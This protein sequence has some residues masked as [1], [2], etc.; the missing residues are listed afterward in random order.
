MDRAGVGRVCLALKAATLDHPFGDDHDAY[1]VGGK[2]FAMVG[3]KGGVSFKVSDIAYE[4]LTETGHARPAPY[5]AKAKWVHLDDP[6]DWPDDE[7]ADHLRT[8]HAL[9][10]AKLTKKAR[11]ELGLT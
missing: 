7:L 1:K 2:M 9:I 6:A 8:A 3:G 5:L 11:A 4:V 10:V